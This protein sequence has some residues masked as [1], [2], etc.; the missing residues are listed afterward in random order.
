[1]REKLEMAVV[2]VAF[3][4][5]VAAHALAASS[6]LQRAAGAPLQVVA[7]CQSRASHWEDGKIV[8]DSEVSIQRMVRGAADST[9]VVRQRGGEV[10]GI[11]QKVTH[12]TLLDPGKTYLLFLAPLADGRWEPTSKGVNVIATLPELGETVAGDPLDQ[13]IAE[14]R[15]GA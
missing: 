3:A 7:L 15:G 11:G 8:S 12:T 13:V 1:M 10:D 5:L 4:L 6:W 9:I 2:F 14:L